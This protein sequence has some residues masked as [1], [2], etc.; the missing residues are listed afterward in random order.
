MML[1]LAYQAHFLKWVMVRLAVAAGG[2]LANTRAAMPL[3]IFPQAYLGFQH[4]VFG[5]AL[6]YGYDITLPPPSAS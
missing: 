4:R 3:V 6:G 5:L 1:D 2:N